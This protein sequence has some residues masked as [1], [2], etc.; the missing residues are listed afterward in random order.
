ML[1][2]RFDQEYEDCPAQY[3]SQK[4]TPYEESGGVSD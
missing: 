1:L 2:S 4:E 3:A